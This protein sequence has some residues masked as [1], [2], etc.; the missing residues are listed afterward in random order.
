MRF[1]RLLL[2]WAITLILLAIASSPASRYPW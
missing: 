1:L 2:T